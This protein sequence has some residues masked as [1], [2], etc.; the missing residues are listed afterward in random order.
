MSHPAGTSLLDFVDSPIIVGDPDGRVIYVN[1]SCERR[2]RASS[3]R[4][5]AVAPRAAA[6]WPASAILT[7]SLHAGDAENFDRAQGRLIRSLDIRVAP[8]IGSGHE[9]TRRVGAGLRDNSQNGVF[10]AIFR[11]MMSTAIPITT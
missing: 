10:I 9:K 1:P 3:G 6:F 8:K 4:R 2:Q 7:L 5:D 11:V